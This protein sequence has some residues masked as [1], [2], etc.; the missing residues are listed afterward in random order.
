MRIAILTNVNLDLLLQLQAKKNEVF[1]TQGYGQWV[2]YA[3]SDDK[4]LIDFEPHTIFLLI[5]GAALL[6]E[7]TSEDEGFSEIDLAMNHLSSFAKRYSKS[8]IAISTMDIPARRIQISDE[9]P[10]EDSWC[11]YW[12]QKLA[13][14][15]MNMRHVHQFELAH[16]ACEV[17]RAN[18]YS[19]KMWYMG[20]IPYSMKGI[21]L[22]SEQIDDFLDQLVIRR[23]KVLILDLDNT[24]WGGVLGEDGPQGITL[25]TSLLGAIYRDAQKRIKELKELGVLLA[26]VSKN[27]PEDVAALFVQN[28]QMV[29][30][31]DDFIGIYANWND[32]SENIRQLAKLLN[33]GLD[34]FVFLDDNEVEREAVKRTLPEVE[35]IEFPN[36]LANLPATITTIYK[37][38]FW[39]WTITKE[40]QSKTKQ[41][42]EETLRKNDFELAVSMDDY[43]LTLNMCITIERAREDQVDRIL[44]LIGKTNQF[45]TC[46]IRFDL[47]GFLAYQEKGNVVYAVNVSDKYGDSGL[48]SVLM[49]RKNGSTATIDNFLMSCRV[50]SRQIEN[51]ILEAVENELFQEGITELHASYLPTEKNKPVIDLWDRLGFEVT[52]VL[53]N[54]EK[55]Y[56]KCLDSKQDSSLI[57]ATWA[58]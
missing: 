15:T 30:K 38:Y 26:I 50:M 54:G 36:D 6:E 8:N 13:R 27:N 25:S 43:L 12:N 3:L 53:E 37:K 18:F 4:A 46:T 19:E 5:D 39:Q 33:L 42:Q 11:N 40:D 22:L 20:S 1:E 31:K 17:G 57:K 49:L 16:F 14:L 10:V 41:Y 35:V 58:E 2:S 52:A 55:K 23:K 45:N 7:C 24:L 9:R 44:Q 29:L 51:A 21:K 47:P 28:T 34:S 32:K 48:I 56:K